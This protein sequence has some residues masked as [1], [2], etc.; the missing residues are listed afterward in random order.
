MLGISL[1]FN[2]PPNRKTYSKHVLDV[3]QL[4]VYFPVRI[5][6]KHIDS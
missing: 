6:L 4:C 5:S 2:P 1:P 3:K